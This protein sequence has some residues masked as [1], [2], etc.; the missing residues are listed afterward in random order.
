M[1]SPVVGYI[2]KGYPRLSET[3][4]LN[5]IYLLEKMGLRL[6]VFSVKKGSSR[7][8]G[9]VQKIRAQATYTPEDTSVMNAPFRVWLRRNLPRYAGSHL[10][11]LLRRPKSYLQTLFYTLFGLSMSI[12]FAS[13]P[14]WKRAFIKDFLRAGYIA[15]QILQHGHIGH[16][17]GHF[18][19]GSTTM[20]MLASHMTGIPFSFTAHAKDI[21][22]P[23]LNP[24]DLLA[25]K[26][27]KAEFVATCT[28]ANRAYLAQFNHNGTPLHTIYHGLD[29]KLFS[30]G[31]RRR[32]R[33][34]SEAP[35]IL[36][37]GRFVEK[38][39][40]VYL[41]QACRLLQEQGFNF[42]CQIVGEPDEQTET[43]RNL[44]RD[45]GL[46]DTVSLHGAVTQAE[47]R[48][49]Y[50][51]ATVFALPCTI[52]DNGDRDGI[53]NVLVEAMA[54]EL[55]VVS[56]P[57]SGIPELVEHRVDGLLVPPRDPAA[58]AGALAELL[59]DPSLRLQLGQTARQKVCRSFDS[60]QTTRALKTLFDACLERANGG[61]A[62]SGKLSA[63]GNPLLVDGDG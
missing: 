25:V 40:F 27:E 34:E 36:A 60:T 26:I 42:R 5:E 23:R 22:L 1:D 32:A 2:M 21:Y 28:A 31:S 39:G 9:I 15:L 50:A 30:R 35:L 11:L 33:N 51:A 37:V 44:I 56:T 12:S 38:K 20:T 8:H 57:I 59:A 41:V 3:F 52:V 53:P 55:P 19:H 49:I 54:M 29:T 6:H 46:Q 24:R 13:W 7:Q 14:Y 62:V 47:L 17:H 10:R 16:L 43:I 61:K 48:D 18:C 4:I 63:F 58:L 45:S